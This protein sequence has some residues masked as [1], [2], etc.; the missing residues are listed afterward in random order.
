[1]LA[2][3][4]TSISKS[5]PVSDLWVFCVSVFSSP[6]LSPFNFQLP[7]LSVAEGS[8]FNWVSITLFPAALTSRPQI[9]EKPAALTPAFATLTNRV[10]HKSC[11]CHSYKKHQGWGIPSTSCLAIASQLGLDW[12]SH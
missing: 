7:A 9:T 3:N 4:S 10:K 1:M 2:A 8:T 11:V 6:N 5:V 12:I